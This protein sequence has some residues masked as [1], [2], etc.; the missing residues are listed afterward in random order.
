MLELIKAEF[1]KSKRTTTNTFVV[2]AP[3]FT[4]FICALWS[5]GQAGAYNWWYTMFL[6]GM[7]SIIS[8]QVILR[9]KSL[10]YKGI[11]L[12]PINKAAVW[13]AK[14]LYV[15]LLV[16]C[17]NV[18]FMIGIEV[19]GIAF[20]TYIP[21]SANV[22]AIVILICTL[23]FTIPISLFLTVKFNMF[24]T[25][26]FNI[27]MSIIGVVSFGSSSFLSSLPYATPSALMVP[28]LRI[29]PNGL[30]VPSD[31]EL[32]HNKGIAMDS[33]INFIVFI[34]LALLTTIWFKRK[35]VNQ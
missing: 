10:S 17:S 34:I 12:Y 35:A 26:L 32:I 18:I 15:S 33:I 21:L 22:L 23:A 5:G 2:I 8:S 3:L 11:L 19:V 29:L 24:V 25:V 16:I 6:P 31:S 20:G 28:I 13:L 1:Q 14:I 7:I 30:P 9:E 27:G 4:L